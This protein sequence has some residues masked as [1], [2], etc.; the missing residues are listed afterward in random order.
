MNER[1]VSAA[2]FRKWKA[3]TISG[4]NEVIA[5]FQ[6]GL[7]ETQVRVNLAWNA[8]NAV[9]R[10]LVKKGLIS[11]EDLRDA[12]VELMAEARANIAKAK[13]AENGVPSIV[14]MT[15]VPIEVFRDGV[16]EKSKE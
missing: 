4:L 8:M 11:E 14:P 5:R 1:A 13:S 12:G 9:I 16:N 3:E 7:V 2:E 10:A 6:S 15:K